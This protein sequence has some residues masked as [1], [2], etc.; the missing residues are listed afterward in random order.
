V[1]QRRCETRCFR[2]KKLHD[3]CSAR[4]SILH[5]L[6][7]GTT[8]RNHGSMY[9]NIDRLSVAFWQRLSTIFALRSVA[10]SFFVMGSSHGRRK[11]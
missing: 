6:F 3:V 9:G 4:M 10:C 1:T 5:L 8:Q 11:I 2:R 7:L